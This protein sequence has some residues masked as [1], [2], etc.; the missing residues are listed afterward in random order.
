[1]GKAVKYLLLGL[2]LFVGN[3]LCAQFNPTNPS[4]PN[5]N[6]YSNVTV[7]VSP[8]AAGYTSGAGRFLAGGTRTVSTSAK[9]NYVF[10]HWTLNGELFSESRSASYT[11]SESDMLFVAHY[12][13]VPAS[14]NEPVTI[15][16][17]ALHIVPDPLGACTF[18][19]ASGTKV[20]LDDWV[21]LTATP[22]SGYVFLGWYNNSTLVS[23]NISFNYQMPASEVTLTARFKYSPDNP[24]EPDS[25][26]SQT[27][28]QT[29]PTGDVNKD[30]TVDVFDVVDVTNAVFGTEEVDMAVYDIN[31]DGVVDVFDV[32]KVINISL[33]YE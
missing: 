33:E 20:E 2:F 16:K 25:D 31:G 8:A 10:S 3:G 21:T 29:H 22:G 26:G 14:P 27:N 19:R 28:V 7:S 11:V 9:A 4:E 18:N 6:I 13:F 23:S 17:N 24:L 15:I 30:G 32:V 1:M 5:L 12:D